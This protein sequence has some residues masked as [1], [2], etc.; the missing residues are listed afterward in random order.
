M[1]QYSADNDTKYLL[2]SIDVFSKYAWVKLLKSK[3][4]AAVTNVFKD[5]L[6]ERTPSK[7]QTGAVTGFHISDFRSLSR[8]HIIKRFSTSNETKAT[9]V[10]PFNK[11]YKMRM[12][13]G[14]MTSVNSHQYIDVLHDLTD[15]AYHRSIKMA[16][17][18]V[19]KHNERE[20]FCNLFKT[21]LKNI[22]VFKHKISDTENFKAFWP[23]FRKGY[24]QH[25]QRYS[26][27]DTHTPQV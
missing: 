13:C 21:K 27:R 1:C 8:I 7:L 18:A 5:I 9:V 19:K 26:Q 22:M 14:D 6:R 16:L 23:I 25:T 20:L 24:E 17:D 10:K 11:S 12:R 4:E 3:M 15:A 2:T